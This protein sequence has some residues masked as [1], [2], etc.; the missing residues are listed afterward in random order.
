MLKIGVDP[1]G[2]PN[3]SFNPLDA[4]QT[5]NFQENQYGS[6]LFVNDQNSYRVSSVPECYMSQPE[7]QINPIP[8][9][10]NFINPVLPQYM[11]YS[12]VAPNQFNEVKNISMEE[13]KIMGNRPHI[14]S[15][16]SFFYLKYIRNMFHRAM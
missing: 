9:N 3:G 14:P 4:S 11:A 8:T 15:G 10:I 1:F 7:Y 2:V 12:N 5:Q 16:I 6:H 13:Q